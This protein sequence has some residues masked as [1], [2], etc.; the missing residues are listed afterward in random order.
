VTRY[1]VEVTTTTSVVVTAP[2]QD[3]AKQIACRQVRGYNKQ[4]VATVVGM[5]P[6]TQPQ[7]PRGRLP[8]TK[9]ESRHP[10]G[11]LESDE[12]GANWR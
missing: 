4:A 5:V 12:I 10:W 7:E 9:P 6:D 3:Q 2:N 8:G 1:L 11:D